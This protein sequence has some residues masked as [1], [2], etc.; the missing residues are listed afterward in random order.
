MFLIL[1]ITYQQI[2]H[3]LTN[4]NAT[5]KQKS[6]FENQVNQLM[7]QTFCK[8]FIEICDFNITLQMYH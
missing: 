6:F 3:R 5:L 1:N 4:K 7:L 2:L 8:E